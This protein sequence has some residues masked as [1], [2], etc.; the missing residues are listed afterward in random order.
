MKYARFEH[1][2]G[3][4]EEWDTIQ[5]QVKLRS[6]MNNWKYHTKPLMKP[7]IKHN[8]IVLN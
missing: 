7:Q 2:G 3:R 4:F 1:F 8:L 6:T 5:I